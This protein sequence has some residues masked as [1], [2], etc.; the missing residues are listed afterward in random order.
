MYVYTFTESGCG[1]ID[2]FKYVVRSDREAQGIVFI[3]ALKAINVN[4]LFYLIVIS[5]QE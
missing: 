3:R 2:G 4:G 1:H 5:T